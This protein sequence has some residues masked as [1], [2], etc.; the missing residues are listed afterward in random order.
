MNKFECS[1]PF[2]AKLGKNVCFP[3][4]NEIFISGGA[5][6]DNNCTIY[7][8]IT[9]GSN[10]L[11]DAWKKGG[12]PKIGNDVFIGAGAKIIGDITVRN[13]V[14]IGSNCIVY[15]NISDNVTVVMN[16]PRIIMN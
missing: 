9:I 7:Q 12:V 6:I 1:I 15:W 13:N 11:I 10:T 3:H 4:F 14:R 2:S 8:Q 5:V 16:M